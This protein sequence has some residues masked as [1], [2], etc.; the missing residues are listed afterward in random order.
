[1]AAGML[2]GR[3]QSFLLLLSLAGC[4]KTASPTGVAEAFLDAYYVERNPDRALAVS[5]NQA[6]DRVRREREL[7]AEAGGAY[8]VQPKVYYSKKGAQPLE[9]AELLTYELSIDSA[10]VR[11]KKEVDVLVLKLGK[12]WKVAAFNERGEAQP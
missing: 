9:G 4:R 2:L 6:E 5:T 11:F 12:E 3:R 8:G 10:G 7:R 1:M